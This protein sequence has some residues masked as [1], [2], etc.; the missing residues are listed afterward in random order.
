ME[1]TNRWTKLEEK[2]LKKAV[3]DNP[4]NLSQAFMAASFILDRSPKACSMHWYYTPKKEK[5]SVVF[6][7]ISKDKCATN[8][9][10]TVTKKP[11]NKREHKTLW[12]RLLNIFK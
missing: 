12:S 11:K 4:G 1:K 2:V 10:N 8:R 9:K 3:S 6:A 5:Q 7:T